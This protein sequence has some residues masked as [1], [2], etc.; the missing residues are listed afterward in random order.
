VLREQIKTVLKIKMIMG[1]RFLV[2][3]IA[4]ITD[5]LWD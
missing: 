4:D 1:M 5:P 2:Q 3:E